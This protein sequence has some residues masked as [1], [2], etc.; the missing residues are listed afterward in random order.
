MEEEESGGR[1]HRKSE[2]V[3]EESRR[4]E[5]RRKAEKAR[6]EERVDKREDQ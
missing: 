2:V 5:W 6:V 1:K 4:G 3:E